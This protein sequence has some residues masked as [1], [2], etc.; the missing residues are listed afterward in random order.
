MQYSNILAPDKWGKDFHSAEAKFPFSGSKV[1]NQRKY[2][3]K[4]EPPR[5]C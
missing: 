5:C 2:G 4:R 1:S 3:K